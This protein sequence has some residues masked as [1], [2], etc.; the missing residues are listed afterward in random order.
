MR[1]L[2]PLVLLT[3]LLQACQTTGEGEGRYVDPL[4]RAGVL[5]EEEVSKEPE[6]ETVSPGERNLAGR[7]VETLSNP[8]SYPI[9]DLR[10]GERPALQT[11]EAG[12]W[13]RLDRVE[14]RI[15]TSGLLLQDPE[16]TAYVREVACRVAGDFCD[17]VRVY[18]ISHPS[19]N[20]SMSPNGT[21]LIFTGAL[22]RFRSE[23]ELA[24]VIGHELGHYLR[25]HSLQQMRD[26]ID[27]TNFLSFFS[28]A[29]SAGIGAAAAAGGP[30]IYYPGQAVVNFAELVVIGEIFAFSRNHERE[31]DGYGLLLMSQAGYEP[32]A[33]A[34]VWSR[35]LKEFEAD[36]DF[37]KRSSFFATHPSSEERQAV[38]ESLAEKVAARSDG[39]AVVGREAYMERILPRRGAFLRDLLDERGFAQME[40]LLDLLLES[41]DPNPAE[42]HY[43]K[44]EIHRLR[45]EEG[46]QEKALQSYQAAAEA[47]GQ[48]PPDLHR[49]RGILLNRK[50]EKAQA[51]TALR[52]YLE[53]SPEAG[54][55][56]F[57]E[58]LIRRLETS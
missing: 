11:D 17:D 49:S 19:F 51:A 42:L 38:L 20:A 46:D 47:A 31:A 50:G 43:F 22:L 10:P 18:V 16:L 55:R 39:N 34:D 48:A 9:E 32:R 6:P 26:V 21:M 56:L 36:E 2:V 15:K 45:D 7:D 29:V 57:I 5:D 41:E 4:V 30:S 58:D 33:F 54:D 14:E 3:T 8:E 44:G 53:L 25:R 12:L 1:C 52:K 13:M 35:L 24:A 28:V 37:K 40:V 27:K 23:A